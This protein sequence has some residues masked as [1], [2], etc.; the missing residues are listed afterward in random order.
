M[1]TFSFG[2]LLAV[3]YLI[4]GWRW[5]LA[6]SVLLLQFTIDTLIVFGT[7]VSMIHLA[8]V[9]ADPAQKKAPAGPAK[10]FWGTRTPSLTTRP[11]S[12]L[13]SIMAM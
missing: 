6:V 13:I 11:M 12:A 9:L 8:S 5:T 2:F 10:T 7:Q 1:I 4:L 3:A